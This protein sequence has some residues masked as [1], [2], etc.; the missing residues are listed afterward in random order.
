MRVIEGYGTSIIFID[1]N[2]QS[3]LF[4]DNT[5]VILKV[6]DNIGY[7][8]TKFSSK[9]FNIVWSFHCNA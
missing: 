6:H 9:Y 8:I 2:F 3:Y 1:G 7:V 5:H 4:Q